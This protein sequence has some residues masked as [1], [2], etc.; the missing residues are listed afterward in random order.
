MLKAKKTWQIYRKTNEDKNNQSQEWNGIPL[1]ILKPL[2]NN[3]VPQTTLLHKFDNLEKIN[4][5]CILIYFHYY[6]VFL[7]FLWD[8]LSEPY[9]I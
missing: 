1:H 4:A 9:I 6:S 5:P 8:F 7:N 3:G 2:K